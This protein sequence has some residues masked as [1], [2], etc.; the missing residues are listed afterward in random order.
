LP[1]N[2]TSSRHPIHRWYNFIAGFSPEFVAEC[3]EKVGGN[4]REVVLLDPFAGCGTSLV[5][6]NLQG[7]ASIGYEAHP[8]FADMAIAKLSFP[9][10]AVVC[11]LIES[12]A[13]KAYKEPTSPEDIW[14]P[15]ALKFLRKLIPSSELPVFASAYRLEA[16]VPT[17]IRSLYRMFMSQVLEFSSISQTDG[18]YKAP[19]TGKRWQPFLE[20]VSRV[21]DQLRHDISLLGSSWVNRAKLIRHTSERMDEVAPDVCDLCVTSPPYLNNFDFAEMTRMELYFWRYADDWRGITELIRRNLVVNTTT[22]PAD[23]KLAQNRF[24]QSVPSAVVPTLENLVSSLAERRRE[25]AGKKEYHL[26]VF[27][28]FGQMTT[29]LT[30][31]FRVMKTGGTLHLVVADSALYGVHIQTERIL[32]SIM[33]SIGFAPAHVHHLRERGYRWA[34]AKRQGPPRGLLGEFHIEAVKR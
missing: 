30:E 28:Y 10:D 22:A 16:T 9:N 19:T 8:F 33:T 3:I 23:L 7:I 18:I 20:G 2:I 1:T 14:A 15:D 24:R 17:H 5:E 31:T 26:L 6:A 21:L 25:R 12:V 13:N 34:L 29:I 4:R 11:D 27:P 32:A